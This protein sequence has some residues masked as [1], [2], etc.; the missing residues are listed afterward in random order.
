MIKSTGKSKEIEITVEFTLK[1]GVIKEFEAILLPH[2]ERVSNEETC[3]LMSASYDQNDETKYFLCER[4][5]DERDFWDVQMK[6][7]YR[8][9]YNQNIAAFEA[10]E[11]KVS[12][13]TPRYFKVKK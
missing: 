7:S 13:Y 1:P 8:I 5:K 10:A 9:P 2:L 12:M 4:W 6:R 11:S 3:L